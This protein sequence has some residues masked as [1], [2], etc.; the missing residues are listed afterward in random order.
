LDQSARKED[1]DYVWDWIDIDRPRELAKEMEEIIGV[2]GI[3]A[4][5]MKGDHHG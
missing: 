2:L 3:F 4:D 1:A 5:Q